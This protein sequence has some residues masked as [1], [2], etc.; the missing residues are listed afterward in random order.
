MSTSQK[1]GSMHIIDQALCDLHVQDARPLAGF[2][3]HI[4]SRLVQEY[5][6]MER[7]DSTFS[8]FG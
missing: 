2:H 4:R 5:N 7:L 1:R 6:E 8:M 3:H